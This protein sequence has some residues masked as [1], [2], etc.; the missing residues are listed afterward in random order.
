MILEYI[1]K[2]NIKVMLSFIA[3]TLVHQACMTNQGINAPKNN[4]LLIWSDE[5]NSNGNVDTSIWRFEKGFVRNHEL[6][7]YQKENAW[8]SNGL[9]IIEARRENKPNP[10]FNKNSKDWRKQRPTIEYTSSSI[11]TSGS[12]QFTYGRFEMRARIKTD[13]GLWPAFWTLGIE[14]EWPSNGEI[15]IMEFY[16]D[17][18]LANIAHGT[19]ERYKA[20]WFSTK[21]PVASFN[22][23]DWQNKFHVWRMDWSQESIS[24]FVDDLLLNKVLLKDLVNPDGFNPFKQPHYVLLNLAI[25]GDNGGDPSQT[26]FPNK[27]EID[28]V[29]VYQ[30]K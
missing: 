20:K 23:T 13:G 9:L 26:Q 30:K 28:Y 6:Q 18:L 14:K 21:K 29:R 15:D 10:L 16:K 17:N 5:F 11:N 24:L 12:K 19:T 25:G 8:C 4:Y 1:R 3:T 7:W 2:R 22:D 27:Y